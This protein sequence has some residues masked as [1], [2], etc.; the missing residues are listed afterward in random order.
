MLFL[1]KI[2]VTIL[3]AGAIYIINHLA[4]MLYDKDRKYWHRII[5]ILC[6][7]IA[8]IAMIWFCIHFWTL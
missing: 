1:T 7:L 5:Y 4:V 3:L 2:I 8:D 6:Y